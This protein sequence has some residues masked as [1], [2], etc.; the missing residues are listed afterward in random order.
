MPH[1]NPHPTP[2]PVRHHRRVAHEA[3][4]GPA[5]L[6]ARRPHRVPHGGNALQRWQR[7]GLYGCLVTLL[8]SGVLWLSVHFLAWPRAAQA[9]VEGLPSPW[10]PWLMKLHGAAMM[11]VLFFLGA[12]AAT[13]VVRGWR[14]RSRRS[15]GVALLIFAAALV[16]TAY[17]LYYWVPDSLRDVVAWVHAGMGLTWV[18][19]LLWHRRVRNLA[20]QSA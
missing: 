19:L 18:G 10:E 7:W 16:L 20:H 15:S 4:P 8:I 6:R 9:A 2:Q 1:R 3:A 11:A 17:A 13:H 14:I 5:K 12:L